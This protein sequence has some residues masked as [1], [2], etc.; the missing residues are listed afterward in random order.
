MAVKELTGSS[1]LDALRPHEQAMVAECAES[2]GFTSGHVFYDPGDDVRYAYFPRFS[3]VTSFH[4]IMA[5]GSAI[6][7]AMVGS[8]GAVGGIVS[9]G[10]LPAYARSCVMHGG[11]FYRIACTD[12]AQLKEENLHMRQ[13]FTRYADCM[14]AQ[15]FQSVACNAV[16]T[17]EQRAAKWLV[18]AMDRTG[19]HVVSM[20]QDQ[21]GSI[22]GVGRTY[23]S[24]V[25]R[26]MKAMGAVKTRRGGIVVEDRR[27]LEHMS[28]DCN[29]LVGQHFATVLGE[30][31]ANGNGANGHNGNGSGNGF[32]NGLKEP[33]TDLSW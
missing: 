31:Y 33:A 16:H 25:I 11:D 15:V 6:E 4:V 3:A 29:V 14:L 21:L 7:T 26:K 32:L 1:L 30:M 2:Y 8:E 22:L 24:R 18:A 27:C 17:I 23:V 19:S 28:C 9:K 20:T 5:D 12:L 10:R 13:L